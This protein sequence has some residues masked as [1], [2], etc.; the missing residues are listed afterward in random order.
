MLVAVLLIF[1]SA[2]TN[3]VLDLDLDI[4]DVVCRMMVVHLSVCS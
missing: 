2:T 4:Y 3:L 1:S